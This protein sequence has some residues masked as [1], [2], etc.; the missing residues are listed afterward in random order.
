MANLQSL[1]ELELAER[2]KH[3]AEMEQDLFKQQQ[4]ILRMMQRIRTTNALKHKQSPSIDQVLRR[5]IVKIGKDSEE[6]QRKHSAILRYINAAGL[7]VKSKYSTMHNEEALLKIINAIT[8]RTD[9]KGDQQVRHVRW[10]HELVKFAIFA[11][12]D[13]YKTNVLISLPKLKRTPKSAR[14]PH[15]PYSDVQLKRIFDPSKQF[16]HKYPDFF[17]GC[18]IAL[19]TGSRKNAVFTLQYKDIVLRDGIWCI[20]F[21]EDCP[22]IKKLKTEDSERAVPIHSTLVKMGFL[23]F[24]HKNP[25]AKPTDFIFRNICLNKKGALNSHMTRKFFRFLKQIGVKGT[26]EN[27]YDFHSF[28]KNA[29]I[30]MEK[31]GI[32]RSYID[33]IIGWQSRGS[34]GERS[35]SNYTTKQ[36]AEQLELLRYTCLR[37]EFPKWRKIFAGVPQE[38]L[39]P[40]QDNN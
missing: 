31:C 22:G 25:D 37:R 30:T 14:R 24:V 4:K 16:F 33:K 13:M 38:N 40:T 7:N 28:R 39:T 8:N 6:A 5:F 1:K 3:I 29:N 35:Y 26:D 19:F 9:I 32:I 17:W 10:I 27:Q 11:Y 12:P 15:T 23:D 2:E 21:I 20:N 36:L 34:E 18:M